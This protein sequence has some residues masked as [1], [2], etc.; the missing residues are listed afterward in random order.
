MNAPASLSMQR[1]ARAARVL[2]DAMG[3]HCDGKDMNI[4]VAALMG[5]I[6][7]LPAEVGMSIAAEIIRTSD[8]T[9]VELPGETTSA[10]EKIVKGLT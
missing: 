1:D 7:R 4:V 2:C 9:T 10:I 3:M 8:P 5:L 6:S